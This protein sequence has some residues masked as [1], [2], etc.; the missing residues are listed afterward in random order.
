MGKG[1]IIDEGDMVK[2]KDTGKKMKVKDISLNSKNQV[3]FS[4][5]NGS[6]L[7]GDIEK[8]MARGGTVKGM[9]GRDRY[10]KLR[11]DKDK[12]ITKLRKEK[13]SLKKDLKDK[14]ADCAEDIKVMKKDIGK[15]VAKRI[16]QVEKQ[17]EKECDTVDSTSKSDDNQTLLLSGIAGIFLGAFLGRR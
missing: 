4:G 1:G 3:E 6:F 15:T 12:E 17:K 13:G 16:D 10:V 14:G 8:V 5:D 11:R 7:I 9:I 2:I